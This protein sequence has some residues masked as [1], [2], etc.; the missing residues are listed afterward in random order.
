M[1]ITHEE[2][3]RLI[4]FKAD[5]GLNS[6]SEEKLSAHLKVCT[7]CRTYAD[8]IKDTESVLRRTLRKQW[9]LHP[10]PLQMDAIY[11]KVNARGNANIFMTTRTA[12][13]GI[14][15]VMF[16]FITWQS[17]TANNNAS[18]QPPLG[19]VPLI[20]TPSTQYTATNTLQNDCK[21][22]KYIV[23]AGD[24]L[25]SIARHFSASKE[26]ILFANHLTDEAIGPAQELL[27]PFCESTPTSTTR[28]PTFTITPNF[29]TISNTPG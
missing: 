3:H 2:A 28:P 9:D 10:L 12:L 19:T 20:P 24:T 1:Q 15:F 27:I 29:E 8:T 6:N 17:L 26:S 21:E 11:A 23:Q 5:N 14:A 16:A 22:I 4:Q 25:E 13:I 7:E 18:L